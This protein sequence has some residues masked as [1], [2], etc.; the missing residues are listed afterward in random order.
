MDA[1]TSELKKDNSGDPRNELSELK[2][3]VTSPKR[4]GV[5]TAKRGTT[6]AAKRRAS[7]QRNSARRKGR[8]VVKSGMA[9]SL[10]VTMLTGLKILRPMRIHPVASWIFVGLTVVH[11][12]IYDPPSK[13]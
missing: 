2:A 9:A 5:V 12:L 7:Q 13:K 8:E 6:A 11:M 3:E 10:A 1:K 4:R